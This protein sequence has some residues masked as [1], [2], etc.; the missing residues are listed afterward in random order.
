MYRRIINYGILLPLGSP[1]KY[2]LHQEKKETKD[3]LESLKNKKVIKV[4]GPSFYESYGFV[5][6]A[7]SE[8][9]LEENN[10]QT[11]ICNDYWSLQKINTLTSNKILILNDTISN[12]N[13][14]DTKTLLF[15]LW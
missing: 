7:M 10:L 13:F 8:S 14:S 3:L 2:L 12:Y 5:I 15:N 6:A 9:N 1:L 11:V 4:A